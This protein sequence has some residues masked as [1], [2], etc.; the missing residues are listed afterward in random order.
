MTT[1]LTRIFRK[2]R[3]PRP[4]ISDAAWLWLLIVA[5]VALLVLT[6][7]ALAKLVQGLMA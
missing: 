4:Q 2:P 6:G 7:W 3:R 5:D 1:L